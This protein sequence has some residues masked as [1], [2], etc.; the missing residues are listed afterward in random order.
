[1][2]SPSFPAMVFPCP[3]GAF[4]SAFL[5]GGKL[6]TEI[7]WNFTCLSLPL[8][9]DSCSHHS[10]SNLFFRGSVAGAAALNMIPAARAAILELTKPQDNDPQDLCTSF[11]ELTPRDLGRMTLSQGIWA[12]IKRCRTWRNSRD[13]C[14]RINEIEES[15][16]D[17]Y[18]GP[19]PRAHKISK[20]GH[21]KK[22]NPTSSHGSLANPQDLCQTRDIKGG[23]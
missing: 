3:G 8:M 4:L 12:C 16:R 22:S 17:G 5:S 10:P 15:S 14:T 11:L 6:H 21:S 23:L 13:L 19:F 20:Q 18:E 2:P 9:K 7:Q 1:M